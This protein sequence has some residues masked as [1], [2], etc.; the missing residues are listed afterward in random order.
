LIESGIDEIVGLHLLQ[1]FDQRP[2][3]HLVCLADPFKR[4]PTPEGLVGV[5]KYT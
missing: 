4:L 1:R 5:R 3:P 2:L